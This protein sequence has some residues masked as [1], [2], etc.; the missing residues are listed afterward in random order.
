M[1]NTRKN[2]SFSLK[3]ARHLAGKCP[4]RSKQSSSK[5]GETRNKFPIGPAIFR[6]IFLEK[7]VQFK[8]IFVPKLY[9]LLKISKASDIPFLYNENGK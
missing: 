8:L 9:C 1:V 4:R 3:S 5:L 7:W 2:K 6:R